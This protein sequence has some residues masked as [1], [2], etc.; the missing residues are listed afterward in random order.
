MEFGAL[1][2]ALAVALTPANLFYCLL[3]ALIGTLVGVLPGLGPVAAISLLLPVTYQLPPAGAIIMLAGIYYGSQYGGSTTS[4]LVNIPGE[5]SSVVT[6][7]DGYKMALKGRAGAALG[8]SAFGSFVGGTFAVIGVMALAPPLSRLAL[9]FG[10]PE[11]SALLLLGIV[12]L[13]HLGSGSRLKASLMAALGLFLGT[14]GVDLTTGDNRFTLGSLTLADGLGLS[15]VAMGLFGIGEVLSNIAD[16]NGQGARQIVRTKIRGL[17]PN[18]EEWRRSVGPMSRGTIV[19]FLLGILPGGGAVISSFVSYALEKRRSR[20]PEEFGQ[21]AIEGV[22]GPETANNAASAGAFIPLLSLGLPANA[23]M[24]I[25]LGALQIHGVQPG[26]L[27]LAQYPE[28]F[29]AIVG[30]MYVGNVLLLLLNL[31]L[32]GVWVQILRVPYKVLFPSILMFAV[33]GSYSIGNNI[34]DVIIMGVM[35]IAGYL[36]RRFGYDAAPLIFG[37]VLS[38]L[39]E[40]AFRQSLILSRGSL[41]IFFTRPLSLVFVVAAILLVVSPQIRTRLSARPRSGQ[42]PVARNDAPANG[43]DG[44]RRCR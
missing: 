35:G 37:L 3:G 18:R 17:L 19:G 9:A 26:P 16:R 30:S 43:R 2:S 29:W 40:T 32:I 28:V 25:L 23:V 12:L 7:I 27:F 13:A 8:I 44:E 42:R 20:R 6:C 14:I 22:A 15:P 24:A 38:P 21:G 36:I 31:P 5:A 10:P 4:V 34:G 1:T 11:Y 33:I 41:L 39:L